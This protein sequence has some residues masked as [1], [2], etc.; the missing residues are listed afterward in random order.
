MT[1]TNAF[2]PKFNGT[3]KFKN[4]FKIA[5]VATIAASLE[6]AKHRN[7]IKTGK[8]VWEILLKKENTMSNVK[9][10]EIEL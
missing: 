2:Y 7:T 3:Q 6:L 5:M 4:E 9:K 8:G 10:E 1:S